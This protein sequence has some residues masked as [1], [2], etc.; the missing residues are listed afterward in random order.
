MES[1]CKSRG[2]VDATQDGPVPFVASNASSRLVKFWAKA[3]M[4]S[5][6][7]NKNPI[8]IQASPEISARTP[9]RSIQI[10]EWNMYCK[11]PVYGSAP[12]E[13]VPKLFS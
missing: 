7:K 2:D 9:Q 13:P 3:K 11:Y 8:N 5:T 12:S 10:V 1:I 4:N 6:R